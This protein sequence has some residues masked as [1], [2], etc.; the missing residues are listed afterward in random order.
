MS[1]F[2]RRARRAARW[3]RVANGRA[4]LIGI[5]PRV[6]DALL[7]AHELGVLPL[8]PGELTHVHVLHD[9]D[10]PHLVMRDGRRGPCRCKPDVVPHARGAA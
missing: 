7:D 8:R 4:L 2:D 5:D 9:D 6:Q 10:C 3:R 1:R